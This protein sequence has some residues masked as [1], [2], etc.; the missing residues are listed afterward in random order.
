MADRTKQARE[1]RTEARDRRRAKVEEPFEELDQAARD[2]APESTNSDLSGA[3]AKV[4]GTAAAAAL[5]GALGGA[6]KTFLER[7]GDDEAQASEAQPESGSDASPEEKAS[8]EPDQDE[9]EEQPEQ[10]EQPVQRADEDELEEDPA[11]AAAAEQDRETPPAQGVSADQGAEIVAQARQQ[12][13]ALLGTEA[14][15]VSGLERVDGGWTVDLEVVE[16]SRIPESTDVL[17]TYELRLDDD[18]NVV[19]VARKRRYR[20]SQVDDDS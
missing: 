6:A 5:L 10:P 16:V 9:R 4:V 13:G 3:A 15:R 1:R 11:P 17:A 19:S 12:L 18:R 8:A 20:R 2:Q 7:R 14:E